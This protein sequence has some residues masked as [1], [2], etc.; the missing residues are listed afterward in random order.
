[1]ILALGG[2]VRLCQPATLRMTIWPEASSAQ[3]SIAA[4]SAEGRT[5]CVLALQL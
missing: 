1:M 3:D 2:S 5:V 4:I